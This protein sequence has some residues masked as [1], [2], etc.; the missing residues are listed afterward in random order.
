MYAYNQQIKNLRNK[1]KSPGSVLV[2]SSSFNGLL[3]GI[4]TVYAVHECT[5]KTMI[6]AQLQHT[7]G[8]KHDD[9]D[10]FIYE[11][12]SRVE[13]WISYRH[14]TDSP[15]K[16]TRSLFAQMLVVVPILVYLI[17]FQKRTFRLRES[18]LYKFKARCQTPRITRNIHVCATARIPSSNTSARARVDAA[19]TED[20]STAEAH[21]RVHDS[22]R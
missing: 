2:S 18:V 14:R 15:D 5:Q 16:K 9:N 21:L 20:R 11:N 10:E 22:I 1:K 6:V 7:D 8:R 19:E 12:N 4:N 17:P 13:W 3:L